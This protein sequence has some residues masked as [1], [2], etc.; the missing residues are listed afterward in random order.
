MLQYYSIFWVANM[1]FH[2]YIKQLIPKRENCTLYAGLVNFQILLNNWGRGMHD[3]YFK[4]LYL[5]II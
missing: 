4:P 5:W 1:Y 3:Y 2:E